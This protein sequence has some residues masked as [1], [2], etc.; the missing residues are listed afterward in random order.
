MYDLYVHNLLLQ[1]VKGWDIH[2]LHSL[3]SESMVESIIK[4]PLFEDVHEDK[5]VWIFENHGNYSVRSGYKH[6][7]KRKPADLNYIVEG[8]WNSLWRIC[9][10]PKIKHLLWRICRGCLPSRTRLKERY[11][12][13]PSDCPLCSIGEEDDWHVF[14]GCSEIQQ[15]WNEAGLRDIIE[16]RLR[17]FNNVKSV[18]FDICS[19]EPI[20][21]AGT[22]AMIMWCIWNNRNSCVW[23]GI[24]DT[25][26]EIASRAAHMLGEWMAVN[27]LQQ[28]N[29]HPAVVTMPMQHAATATVQPRQFAAASS[30]SRS[31]SH[32]TDVLQWQRPRDGWWK[33]NVD[34][35][36]SQDSCFTGWGWCVR[37]SN[38]RFVA[39]G[40]NNC[41]HVLTIA[42]GEAMAILEA[43]RVATS[44]GW[45]NIVFESDSKVVVEA[46]K[47]NPKGSSE[48][49]SF[50]SS[51]K[52][53]LQC[54][55]N[56]EVK[57][58]RRQANMAAHT[59]ARAAISWTSRTYFN[60]IPLVLNLLLVM[61]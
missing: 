21:V 19:T 59:L 26:K 18:I 24:K 37:D 39:A 12:P 7:I 32:V 25:A 17:I 11:V 61:I 27:I 9:A 53:L 57:F 8:D 30:S 46:I 29:N 50:I 52:A 6:F 40:T 3:F 23:N 38:G 33:C 2:K 20:N 5:L 14:F 35:S 13:C 22:V 54:N 15:V 51:I 36:L 4:T 47:A 49:F 42:E 60:S 34:A 55:P 43:M 45:A 16:P 44:K 48:L 31:N 28:H 41:K 56:Y 10:P 1:D 58:V